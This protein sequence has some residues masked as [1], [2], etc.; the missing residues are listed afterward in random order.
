MYLPIRM[1]NIETME[2]LRY[3]LRQFMHRRHTNEREKENKDKNK[4]GENTKGMP[5]TPADDLKNGMF[6]NFSRFFGP[7]HSYRRIWYETL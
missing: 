1:G 3:K 6:V 2:F 7:V 4:G 5:L